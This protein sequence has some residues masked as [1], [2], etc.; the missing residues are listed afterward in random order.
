MKQLLS[1]QLTDQTAER[2]RL[3]HAEAIREQQQTPFAGAK[4]IKDRA[5]ADGVV[6]SIAHGLG[7]TPQFVS[8]SCVRGPVTSGTV[9]EIRTGVDRTQYVALKA[10]GYGATV[11]VDVAVL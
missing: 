6:S 9:E 1:V 10:S 7:R 3:S 11:T 2:V 4:I 8:V 5:L